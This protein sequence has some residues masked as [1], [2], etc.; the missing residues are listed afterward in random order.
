MQFDVFWKLKRKNVVEI[1]YFYSSIYIRKIIFS[2]TR[3]TY[4]CQK[5]I[6]FFEVI[7]C[8]LMVNFHK[9]DGILLQKIFTL[10]DAK[11]I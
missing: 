11:E 3:S 6:K 8:K 5:K 7:V 1:I 2:I 4:I 9:I 10:F